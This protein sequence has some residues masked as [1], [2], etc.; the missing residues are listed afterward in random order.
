MF[1]ALGPSISCGSDP[2]F[3]PSRGGRAASLPSQSAA[4]AGRSAPASA[5]APPTTDRAVR[6]A[7]SARAAASETPSPSRGRRWPPGTGASA[8][9]S[10]WWSGTT[11]LA[12]RAY[13]WARSQPPKPRPP[14][15][16]RQHRPLEHLAAR[17][18]ANARRSPAAP[19]RREMELDL[20]GLGLPPATAAV[21][22]HGGAY[23]AH[24]PA[25]V[26]IGFR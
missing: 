2:I 1:R 5:P 13:F 10:W 4:R 14:I 22:G 19:G 21:V 25:A 17:N 6:T 7:Q 20:L 3:G 24:A 12:S 23:H 16:N 18:P 8:A 11:A 15:P 26:G 9:N